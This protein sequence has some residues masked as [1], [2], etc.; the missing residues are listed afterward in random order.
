M[1][2]EQKTIVLLTP[3]FAASED[4][5]TC[6]PMQYRFAKRMSELYP[7]VQVIVLAFQYPYHQTPYKIFG[8]EVIPFG[9]KN[10]GGLSRLFLRK[11]IYAALDS[12]RNTRAIAGL[13]SFWYGECAA[14]AAKY[15]GKN[16]LKHFCWIRGQDAR[17]RNKYIQRSHLPAED[18][19]ALSEELAIEFRSNYK[20]VPAH[21]IP[22]GVDKVDLSNRE[23]N[24]DLLAAG[25]LIQLKR[26]DLFIDILAGIKRKLPNVKACIAGKGPLHGSLQKKIESL[27]LRSNVFM[28]GEL[29]HPDLMNLM[30]RTKI[31]L[32]PSSYEGFPAVCL[33]AL[34]AGAHVISFCDPMKKEIEKWTVV[35]DIREMQAKAMNILQ[36]TDIRFESIVPFN[37]DDSVRSVMK[38]FESHG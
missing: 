14:V 28:P 30:Q 21:I 8:V 29:S 1:N 37:L 24:I 36:D 12:I 19:I 35:K 3:G 33:E 17:K 4:D 32:H 15:A 18:L 38:L 27:G 22:P 6:L 11:K 10:K 5:T 9:G 2:P 25:S 13:V 16:Q 7:G 20:I 23:R 26:F 34:A 31:L